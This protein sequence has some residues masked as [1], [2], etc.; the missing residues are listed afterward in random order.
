MSAQ[1]L[2]Q[3]EEAEAAEAAEAAEVARPP[4]SLLGSLSFGHVD[5]DAH[6]DAG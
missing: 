1:P 4:A 2:G 5:A 6:V 3:A